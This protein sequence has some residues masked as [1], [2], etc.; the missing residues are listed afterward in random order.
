MRSKCKFCVVSLIIQRSSRRRIPE[1]ASIIQR[2][3]RQRIPEG[4]K[5]P[6]GGEFLNRRLETN[7]GGA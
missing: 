6:L 7:F 1:G 4:F 3:S 5:D 2:S